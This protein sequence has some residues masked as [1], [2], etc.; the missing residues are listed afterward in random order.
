MSVTVTFGLFESDKDKETLNI[1]QHGLDFYA[2]AAVFIDSR[3]IL[4]VDEQHSQKERRF[5]CT[6]KIGRR[7]A[8]VRFT[9]RGR[10]IRIIGAGYWRK[11]R[12][13]Y[14]KENS[15]KPG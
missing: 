3:R 5:F 9:K 10:R 11:G 14:E 1:A 13:L 4:A 12:R 2:A 6:G 7:I 15:K 8:T